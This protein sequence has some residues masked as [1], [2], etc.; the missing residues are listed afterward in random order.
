M[1]VF[2][3]E[4]GDTGFKI[5]RG[6][7]DLF[8]V[9]MVVFEDHEAALAADN[10]IALLRHEMGKRATFEFHFTENSDAVRQ[11]FFEAL[12][13]YNFYF[14]SFVLDK[15]QLQHLDWP[16][17]EAFYRYI[18]GLIF[19]SA[20]PHLDNAIVKL[21]ACGG[22]EFRTEIAAYLKRKINDPQSE[23]RY[24]KKV[25]S[26]KSNG[27]NLLQLADMV[28]GAVA[29]AQMARKPNANVYY[30]MIKHREIWVRRWPD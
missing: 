28:C 2:F 5:V 11:R 20:K 1:L 13:V 29:R 26:A 4:S 23:R 18:C 7:S 10:R 27:N 16:S 14:F 30:R 22:R 8:T 25:V 9:T 21:D 24:L 3:D 15:T 12:K 6:S 17:S 19:E